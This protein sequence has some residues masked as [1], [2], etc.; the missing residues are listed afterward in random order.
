[1]SVKGK[2]IFDGGRFSLWKILMEMGF[3]YQKGATNDMCMNNAT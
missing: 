2:G 3:R 1:M